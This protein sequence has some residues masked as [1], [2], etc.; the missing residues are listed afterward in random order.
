[1]T[2]TIKPCV[3]GDGHLKIAGIIIP[4]D[5]ALA[6]ENEIPIIAGH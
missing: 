6:S 5:A 3:C 1:M 2:L 4:R